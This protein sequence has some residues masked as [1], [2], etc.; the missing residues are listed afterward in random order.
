M[1]PQ[2][3]IVSCFFSE[4]PLHS[5]AFLLAWRKYDQ[6]LAASA[7]ASHSRA[8]TRTQNQTSQTHLL[9]C[10]ESVLEGLHI[11]L[12]RPGAAPRPFLIPVVQS[13]V[14]PCILFSFLPPSPPLFIL[15]EFSLNKFTAWNSAL[16]Q[17]L[18]LVMVL[19]ESCFVDSSQNLSYIWLSVAGVLLPLYSIYSALLLFFYGI[20]TALQVSRGD[21]QWFWMPRFFHWWKRSSW[22]EREVW[23]VVIGF[24]PPGSYQC[25][26]DRI[27]SRE[28]ALHA[29]LFNELFITSSL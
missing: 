14:L 23:A 16:E 13:L 8:H 19:T 10:S 7:Q 4:L 6:K 3:G 12:R 5:H 15:F 20:Y 21:T 18:L 9:I 26:S 22:N 24:P 29:G 2:C 1:C 28:A 11:I 17:C 25:S 27:Q